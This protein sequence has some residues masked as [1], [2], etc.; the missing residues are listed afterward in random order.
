LTNKAIEIN[1]RVV[2]RTLIVIV[3]GSGRVEEEMEEGPSLVEVDEAVGVDVAV[4]SVDE[5]G[6]AEGVAET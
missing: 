3:A 4:I 5:A 6:D 2:E 1:V